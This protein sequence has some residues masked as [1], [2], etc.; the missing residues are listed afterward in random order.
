MD[1]EILSKPAAQAADLDPSQWSSTIRQKPPIQQNCRN[2][3]TN[4]EIL[5]PF[6]IGDLWKNV[7]NVK[8]GFMTESI[9][10]NRLD[11]TVSERYFY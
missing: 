9:I 8:T 7:D 4:T 1:L 2:F 10:F 5:M 11:M 3:W 6:K